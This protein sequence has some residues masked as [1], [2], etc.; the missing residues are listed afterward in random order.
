MSSMAK[1][2]FKAK[3]VK[4]FLEKKNLYFRISLHFKVAFLCFKADFLLE[5]KFDY[6]IYN[7]LSKNVL[8]VIEKAPR[9]VFCLLTWILRDIF[10]LPKKIVSH[11]PS[12]PGLLF[13][14]SIWSPKNDVASPFSLEEKSRK[15][16]YIEKFQILDD[17]IAPYVPRIFLW[18]KHYI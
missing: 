14:G 5:I 10:K 13:S 11:A 4:P 12:A 6:R 3:S 7:F 17:Y 2:H 16:N 15:R 9:I 18:I 8:F 1:I